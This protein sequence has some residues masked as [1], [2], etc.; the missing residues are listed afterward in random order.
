M[1]LCG[2]AHGGSFELCSVVAIDVVLLKRL[3][4]IY[5][6][7]F[8]QLSRKNDF[9]IVV[10]VGEK[11]LWNKLWVHNYVCW[12]KMIMNFLFCFRSCACRRKMRIFVNAWAIGRNSERHHEC[13]KNNLYP[14]P[15]L[16]AAT[17]PTLIK[18]PFLLIVLGTVALGGFHATTCLMKCPKEIPTEMPPTYNKHR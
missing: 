4:W 17:H 16:A 10:F 2:R 15:F 9:E 13:R 1:A 5:I 12:R 6:L 3:W 18:I 8:L 11:W 7:L 14:Q